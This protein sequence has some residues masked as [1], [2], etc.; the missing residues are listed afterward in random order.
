MILQNVVI[1]AASKTSNY[2]ESCLSSILCL[3]SR[4]KRKIIENRWSIAYVQLIKWSQYNINTKRKLMKI[5]YAWFLLDFCCSQ[6]QWVL[7][8]IDW[9]PKLG[10]SSCS[11]LAKPKLIL[12]NWNWSFSAIK[13][14]NFSQ[15]SKVQTYTCNLIYGPLW[16]LHYICHYIARVAG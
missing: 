16:W 1:K 12:L 8:E 9:I 2:Q 14:T 7:A 15:N 11:V 3:N 10:V 4:K 6:N 13:R 5:I